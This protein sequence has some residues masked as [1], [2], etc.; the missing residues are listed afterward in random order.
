M[1]V[2]APKD[3]NELQHM[4]WSALSY[5]HPASVRFP[6]GNGFGLARDEKLAVL[7]LGKGELLKEGRD[8]L[9][10]FGTT[11]AEAL[12]AAA[13]LEKD[14]ISLAVVNARFAKPLDRE[15]LLRYAQPGRAVITV[16]EGVLAGGLGS[17]VR[18]LLDEEGR[19]DIRFKALGI[20]LEIYPVGKAAEIRRRFGLD[21]AGLI[22]RIKAFYAA[23]R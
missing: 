19:F 6:K 16:E 20:P 12:E 10:A 2:M 1:I 23:A 21:T 5:R 9:F 17:A 22:E 11:A 7:P 18:E 8:L 3:E 13:A 14:G 4:L 15:I